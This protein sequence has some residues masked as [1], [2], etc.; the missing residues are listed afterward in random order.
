MV[1]S[2]SE[3]IEYFKMNKSTQRLVL[4]LIIYFTL[5]LF[6]SLLDVVR[7]LTC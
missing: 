1:G 4:F 3:K 7:V 6:F 5:L 2:K